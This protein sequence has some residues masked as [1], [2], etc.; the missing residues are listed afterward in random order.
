MSVYPT[1]WE[2]LIAAC[3]GSPILG[4]V[5]GDMPWGD[6]NASGKPDSTVVRGKLI[7]AD[8]AKP[9]LDYAYDSGFGA[10]D[11]H[12]VYLWTSNSVIFVS[13]YDGSTSIKSIPRNP[14][15]CN[16]TAPGGG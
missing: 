3:D 6:Y 2:D 8:D 1:F 5:I 13:Q 15:D 9:Y 4:V 11:C 7:S 12:A 14:C 16:P 10:P